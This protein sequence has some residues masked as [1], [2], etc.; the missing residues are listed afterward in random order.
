M[1]GQVKKKNQGCKPMGFGFSLVLLNS[2]VLG[3]VFLGDG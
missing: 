3:A 2:A 1:V